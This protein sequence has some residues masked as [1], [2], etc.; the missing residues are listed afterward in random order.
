MAARGTK[1]LSMDGCC[2]PV[3]DSDAATGVTWRNG[4]TI[5]PWGTTV[6]AAAGAAAIAS[7]VAIPHEH[8]LLGLPGASSNV[9]G[10]LVGFV[11]MPLALTLVIWARG[12]HAPRLHLGH[13]AACLVT[14]M[15]IGVAQFYPVAVWAGVGAPLLLLAAIGRNGCELLTVPNLVLRRNDYLFCLPFSPIDAWE[16]RRR[17]APSPAR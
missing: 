12:R 4:R 10:L 1:N 11:G 14:L 8:P 15:T 7:A 16:R 9:V 6:R 2:A 17:H 3:T 5:G 13:S